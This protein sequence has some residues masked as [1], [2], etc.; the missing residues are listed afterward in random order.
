MGHAAF[1]PNQGNW[2]MMDDDA[3]EPT[4]ALAAEN[5]KPTLADNSSIFRIRVRIFESGG[6]SNQ[7]NGFWRLEHSINESDWTVLGSGADFNYADG[8]A[9]EDNTVTTNKL[10]DT[11]GKGP[12][13]ESDGE[14]TFDIAASEDFEFDFSIVPVSAN[15]TAD[16]TYFFRILNSPNGSSYA[17]IVLGGETHP[18]VISAGPDPLVITP[19]A[20]TVVGS[21]VDPTVVV[22]KDV[23]DDL[24]FGWSQGADVVVTPAAITVVGE[25]VNPGVVLGDLVLSDQI[26]A[27]TS[28]LSPTVI[29]GDIV[30]TPGAIA[31][32]TGVVD[33]S[34]VLGDDIFTPGTI[35]SIGATVNPTVI[36]GSLV[37]APGVITV[38]TSGLD[39]TVVLATIVL[40]PGA[41]SAITSTVDPTVLNRTLVIPGPASAIASK[42]DPAFIYGDINFTPG[43]IFVIGQKQDPAVHFGDTTA[44]PGPASAI[45]GSLD[46]T[47]IKGPLSLTDIVEAVTSGADPTIILGDLHITPGSIF[48]I[49]DYDFPTVVLGSLV[50]TPTSIFSV[51]DKADPFVITGGLDFTPAAISAITERN[52][53]IVIFGSVAIT[54]AQI[55]AIAIT[56]DPTV[57][58]GALGLSPAAISAITAALDPAVIL[59]GILITPG[60]GAAIT[61]KVDPSLLF[62][63]T[64]A[65]PAPASAIGTTVGPSVVL[66]S[67]TLTD[68]I[69]VVAEAID[70]F[71]VPPAT[72]VTPAAISAIVENIDPAVIKGSITILPAVASAIAAVQDPS[73]VQTGMIITAVIDAITESFGPSVLQGSLT[74]STTPLDAVGG[75]IDPTVIQASLILA[76]Q[77]ATAIA[78]VLD[79]AVVLPSITVAPVPLDAVTDKVDPTV[80]LGATVE[81]YTIGF[82]G[83]YPTIAAFEL[84]HRSRD[85]VVEEIIVRGV[86]IDN[87]FYDEKV[88]FTDISSTNQSYY[89]ELDVAPGV[90]HTGRPGT[91]ARMRATPGLVDPDEHLVAG[92][93]W[94]SIK[95]LEF[96][97]NGQ[98]IKQLVWGQLLRV[99]NCFAHNIRST[100]SSTAGFL[101]SGSGKFINSGSFNI[102]STAVTAQGFFVVPNGPGNF[103][104]Y[105]CWTDHVHAEFIGRGYSG[106]ALGGST[107]TFKNCVAGLITGTQFPDLAAGYE[108]GF[109]LGCNN[110]SFTDDAPGTNKFNDE[111]PAELWV[112]S[113]NWD[114]RPKPG[115]VLL[116]NGAD[117]SGI[118]ETDIV[119]KGRP[120]DQGWDIGAFEGLELII[121]RI[122]VEAKQRVNITIDYSKYIATVLA[123]QKNVD[124]DLTAKEFVK[125][126][127]EAFIKQSI[128]IDEREKK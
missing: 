123:Q 103:S 66:G 63:D 69:S 92:H 21:T 37:I 3:A 107:I 124:S 93:G 126:Q 45:G 35:G 7:N 68:I 81:E 127:I 39:P 74:I 20:I 33:P 77:I 49:G 17:E 125:K 70:P 53:P 114:F 6:D 48:A 89:W 10:S 82:G 1:T 58:L 97:G 13:R 87:K 100:Q 91:G 113:D 22:D 62:G 104:F 90:R 15:I 61:G 101:L 94:G 118:F 88:K 71:V 28:T 36:K 108:S 26:E 24:I 11:S 2:R 31:A 9:T 52:N 119:G 60:P 47:V 65:T 8:Q 25:K 12:Y 75:A 41:I 42:V 16:T 84:D 19:V 44:T 98:D 109:T 51:T 67:L 59:G 111:D 43:S 38:V 72:V 80:I 83:D 14:T 55:S 40:T 76:N 85:F 54:P 32:I 4:T 120:I 29:K 18:Q 122:P 112:D 5:V 23:I 27:I 96:D 73:V 116:D 78:T 86:L 56:K 117:L 115:S 128:D 99:E 50:V 79:P 64:T 57:V 46:P 30:L 110:V 121:I 105:N 95:N 102:E 34:V 106:T